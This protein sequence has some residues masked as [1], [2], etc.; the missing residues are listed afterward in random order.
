MPFSPEKV[1]SCDTISLISAVEAVVPF[2]LRRVLLV[3][4]AI[5]AASVVLPTPE[6][7]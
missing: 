3:L 4:L 2:S 1:P 5:Y 7:P 6:G